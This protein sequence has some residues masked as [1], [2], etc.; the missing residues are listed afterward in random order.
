MRKSLSIILTVLALAVSAEVS[1]KK[2]KEIIETP[3]S[4]ARIEFT[5]RTL[6]E[7]NDVTYDWS[8]VYFRVKFS[9]PYLAMKCSDTKN[10]WFNLWIDKE[11]CPEADRKFLVAAK[12]TVIALAEGL[13][14]GEPEV[15][16]QKRTE[17]EQ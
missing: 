14:Q 10:S 12:D 8:G 15:M 7:G 4:D 5:G 13:G 9:G 6:V 3:A 2:A 1:A 17:G 11:M 16:L